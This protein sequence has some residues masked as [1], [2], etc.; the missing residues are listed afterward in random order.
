MRA[1]AA[2]LV[3]LPALLVL[4]ACGGSE[5][6][7]EKSLR[8]SIDEQT[9]AA[10]VQFVA[11]PKNVK[12]GQTFKCKAVIPVDVTQLDQNGNIRWQITNL[13]GKPPGASGPTGPGLG[14]SGLG[15]TGITGAT[16]ASGPTF[17]LG[18]SGATGAVEGGKVR[19]VSFRN[20]RGG[21]VIKRPFG[22]EQANAGTVV[23]FS[24][25][26]GRFENIGTSSEGSAPKPSD[27]KKELSGQKDIS[28]Q[29][30]VTRTKVGPISALTITYT[31]RFGKKPFVI[32][33]YVYWRNGKRVTLSIGSP[34]ENAQ[35]P[36]FAK[37]VQDIAKSFRFL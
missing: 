24:A 5:S 22:W 29:S 19:L 17:P 26:T 6:D 18:T 2:A 33:R 36:N 12:T 15:A 9:T 14:T 25:P 1:I 13:S 21:Y 4:Q 23:K 3:L 30:A 28:E 37:R 31:Q 7:L 35:A 32:R 8:K 34:K 27:V 10:D 20:R 16:G 11:C